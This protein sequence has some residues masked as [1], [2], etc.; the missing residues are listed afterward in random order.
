M[1]QEGW[2]I[3]FLIPRV[4]AIT[5]PNGQGA[6]LEDNFAHESTYS[7][8]LDATSMTLAELK[9]ELGVMEVEVLAWEGPDVPMWCTNKNSTPFIS[10]ESYGAGSYPISHLLQK[11]CLP[12]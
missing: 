12:E 10:M 9:R 8:L 2:S 11:S 3:S 4:A 5:D 7:H 6:I 1:G